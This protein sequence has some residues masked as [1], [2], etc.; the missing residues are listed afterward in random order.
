[1]S[2]IYLYRKPVSHLHMPPHAYAHKR[3]I[4]LSMFGQ[5][6]RGKRK[7]ACPCERVAPKV[8]ITLGVLLACTVLRTYIF[9]PTSTYIQNVQTQGKAEQV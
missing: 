8:S 4:G 6:L 3:P 7:A 2:D 1:M 5:I 9:T